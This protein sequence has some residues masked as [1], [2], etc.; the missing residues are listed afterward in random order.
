MTLEANKTEFN[1]IVVKLENIE[2]HP[3]ADTLSIVQVNG[4]PVVF[5]TGSFNEGDLAVYIPVDAV[6]PVSRPEFAFLAKGKDT[7]RIKA[8]RL[9]KVFSMGLLVPVPWDSIPVVVGQDMAETLG[10]TKYVT[11]EERALAGQDARL[12]HAANA[13]AAKKTVKLPVYGLDPLRKYENVLQPG[14]QVVVTEKIHGTNARFCFTKGRLWVG[15]HKVMRGASRSRVQ[16]FFDR[17]I[18]KAKDMLGISHRAH[19]LQAAGDVW[20]QTAEQYGLKEK[21][22]KKPDYVLYGEIY[23]EAVQDLKYDSPVGRK[24]RAFDVY[25]LK[26]GKFLDYVDFLAF[27]REIGLDD[28]ND[29]VPFM[30]TGNWNDE[31]GTL[32]K[33]IAN[34]GKSLLNEDQITEGVVV[35]PLHERFDNRVGRVALKFVGENYLLRGEK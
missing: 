26:A 13:R 12:A 15:S 34:V 10:V 14:E 8:V 25:D 29:V 30:F 21:L 7:H 5:K 22:A 23:G 20:W 16:E 17:L 32:V 11:P 6:V 33:N 9:R 18:L 3:E 35:K 24:F 28:K 4:Y 27:V 31:L 19:T 2:K 1:V